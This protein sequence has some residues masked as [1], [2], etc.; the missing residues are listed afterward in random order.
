MPPEDPRVGGAHPE[1]VA[2]SRIP[3]DNVGLLGQAP[4]GEGAARRDEGVSL[5]SYRGPQ[6]FQ[7]KTKAVGHRGLGRPKSQ[8]SLHQRPLPCA[9]R[10][11]AEGTH[12]GLACGWEGAQTRVYVEPGVAPSTHST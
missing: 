1:P 10:G 6:S 11:W 2:L 3:R 5:G 8:V 12:W 9:R 7:L 4:G